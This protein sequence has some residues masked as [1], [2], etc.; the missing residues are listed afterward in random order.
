MVSRFG[1]F[2]S[3][4]VTC[5]VAV[6]ESAS[7]FLL[8]TPVQLEIATIKTAASAMSLNLTVR[9]R[10]MSKLEAIEEAESANRVSE[11][12]RSKTWY[13]SWRNKLEECHN[14][15]RQSFPAISQDRYSKSKNRLQK[16]S[17][18]SRRDKME[19][20]RSVLVLVTS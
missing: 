9:N 7:R 14:G 6:D 1:G 20:D 16:R 4:S 10:N 13:L 8:V 2:R 11:E 17:D 15:T 12:P 18:H 5:D 19:V 3:I